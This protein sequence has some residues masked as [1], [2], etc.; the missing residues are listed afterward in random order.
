M[1][2]LAVTL[3]TGYAFVLAVQ[4]PCKKM[5]SCHL[6]EYFAALAVATS[7]TLIDNM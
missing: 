4:C 5:L 1:L 6:K 2:R 3:A 7:L